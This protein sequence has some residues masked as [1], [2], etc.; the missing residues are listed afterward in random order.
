MAVARNPFRTALGPAEPPLRAPGGSGRTRHVC[1]KG[2]YPTVPGTAQQQGA[3]PSTPQRS[4]PRGLPHLVLIGPVCMCMCVSPRVRMCPLRGVRGGG[5]GW[6]GPG[7]SESPR[8]TPARGVGTPGA[9]GGAYLPVLLQVVVEDLRVGLLMRGQDVHEGGGGVRRRRRGV[10]GA[11]AAQRRRQVEGGCR[12]SSVKSL[13]LEGL[14]RGRGQR[15]S[16]ARHRDASPSQHTSLAGEP[17]P[18]AENAPIL[19]P[20]PSLGSKLL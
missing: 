17:V 4:A 19:H 20:Q 15:R 8:D 11:A 16:K 13:L 1:V 18:G 9:G 5:R 6:G 14:L 2:H 12:G 10:D 7:G 3:V